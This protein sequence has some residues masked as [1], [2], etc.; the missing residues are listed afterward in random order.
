MSLWNLENRFTGEMDIDLTTQGEDEARSAGKVLKNVQLDIAFTSVLKRAIHTLTI[1]LAE[2]EINIPI[3]KSRALNERN[4]GELQGFNKAEVEK[5]YGLEKVLLW[6]RSYATRPPGGESLEDTFNRVVP[7]YLKEI[8]P[9][10]NKGKTVLIVAH[11]NSL[12]A[13]IMYLENLNEK[14]IESLDVATGIPIVFEFSSD[15]KFIKKTY[16]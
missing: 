2:M 8:R 16:L 7:Y 15:M 5:E 14:A 1:V 10:L 11:G 4:Y 3:I 12:R 13:L 6:R 9:F